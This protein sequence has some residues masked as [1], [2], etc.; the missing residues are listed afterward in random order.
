[1]NNYYTIEEICNVKGGKRIPVG[2]TLQEEKNNHPYIRILDMYQGRIIENNG[3]LLYAKDSYINKIKSYT[4]D[5]NDVILAIVGNTLGMVSTIGK[6]LDG[7]NLTENCCKFTSLDE[8][9]VLKLFLYYALISPINIAKISKFRVG[10]SQPKLPLYNVNRLLIPK[11]SLIEQNSIVN[12]LSALDN[13]IE[14]NN[15]INTELEKIAKTLY[16]YWFVQ[17]DFP[18]ENGKPYKS[19]GGKMV[20]NED[21]K[22]KL[23]EGWEVKKI[24][25][26]VIKNKTKQAK[27]F[28]MKLI[29]LSIMPQNTM[30]LNQFSCGDSFDTNLFKMNKFDILF[31]SI[32]PYLKKAGFAPFNG[33][34]SGTIYSFSV[35]R[36]EYFNFVLMTMVHKSLFDYAIT[37]SKGTKMPVIGC[38]D[39]LSYKVAFNEEIVKKFN[40]ILSFKEIISKNIQENQK[41]TE[42]RDWLLPM[43]MNGQVTIKEQE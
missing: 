28:E 39:L 18:D 17:F 16:D 23:P 37:N 29:D 9:K 30:C 4:V 35:Q 6:S 41:L 2:E 1:M 34:V 27:N 26:L 21:L 11:Y 19:S 20:Y 13:K 22:R 15:K 33:L 25:E 14:L 40:T 31:G 43:L 10:S 38:D 3:T 36:K 24:S 12:I 7:A 5:S 8:K 42:L 32:R